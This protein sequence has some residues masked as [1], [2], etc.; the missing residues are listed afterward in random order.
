MKW[1]RKKSLP[2]IFQA[3]GTECGLACLAM[4][5]W[6]HGQECSLEALRRMFPVSLKGLSLQTVLRAADRLGLHSRLL[7]GEVHDLAAVKTPAMLHW[8]LEHLVVLKAVGGDRL[9]IHDPARGVLHLDLR[10]VSDHFTGIIVELDPTPTFTASK[11]GKAVSLRQLVGPLGP[12]RGPLTQILLLSVLLELL[13]LAQPLLLRA[14]V[15]VGIRHQHALFLVQAAGILVLAALLQGAT[16]FLRDWAILRTGTDLNVSV[17]ERIF[18]TTLRLPLSYFEKRPIGHLIER[19][20]ITDDI[21]QFMVGTLP[22]GLMDGLMAMISLALVTSMS[23]LCGILALATVSVFFMAQWALSAQSRS[24]EQALQ[25]AKR[26]ENGL[27]IE[28]LTTIATTKA[29]AIEPRRFQLWLHRMG[30]LVQEQRRAGKLAITFRSLKTVLVGVNLAVLLLLA[31]FAVS[32]G[33]AS[34]G[35]LI[36]LVFYNTHFLGKATVLVERF[37]E[38]RLLAVRLERLEDL[39]QTEPEI[40]RLSGTRPATGDPVEPPQASGIA[41]S[42]LQGAVAANALSFSYSPMEPMVLNGVDLKLEQ[43]EFVALVGANGAGKTTLLKLLLGLYR[44]C[45]GQILYDGVDLWSLSTAQVRAQIGLVTQDDQFF[46]GSIAE[47]IALF[48]PELDMDQVILAAELACVH[49]DVQRTPMKYHSRVGQLS[50]PF[51]EG[52]KQKLLL[53]RALYRQPK[54]I[55]LDEGTANLD[56]A[57]EQQVLAN[58]YRMESTK[59]VI[60]HRTATLQRADR[61]LQLADGRLTEAERYEPTLQT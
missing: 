7:R 20:R 39:L 10:E 61:V 46:N 27:L 52:Q 40:P 23:P 5:A 17:G 2:M 44:P 45:G 56:S 34:F 8:D 35:T 19:Y 21:E 32:H 28:T 55:F 24:R 42:I 53:A 13:Y 54:L 60:A 47:N 48:D 30:C 4:I 1:S 11:H 25:A 6:F 33:R 51:S 29:N 22:L 26:E 14:V 59:L 57:S 12:W 16:H 38:F 43:G 15:D 49:Q 41:T 37:F 50:S 3:E 36:A 31:G 58:L 18:H 9:T